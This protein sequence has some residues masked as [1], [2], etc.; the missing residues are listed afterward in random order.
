MKQITLLY[1]FSAFTLTVLSQN[2]KFIYYL[3]AGLNSTTKENAA[4]IGRAYEKDGLIVMDCYGKTSGK[5]ILSATFKDSTLGVLHG[6]YT[7]YFEN[8]SIEAQGKYNN[9]EMDGWWKH[10]VR[11]GFIE[12]SVFYSNG[13][14]TIFGAYWYSFKK[15]YNLKAPPVDS[16]KMEGYHYRYS[17]TDSLN[18]TFYEKSCWV[19]KGNERI[20]YEVNF[21]GNRGLLKEY[22]STGHV[23]TDSVFSREATEAAFPGGEGAWRDFLYR[24]LN[25]DI[26]SKN[27]APSGIYTVI[28]KF[29]VNKDGTLDEITAENDA[30]YG[31]AAEAVR[32]LKLSRKWKPAFQYGKYLKAYRRQPLSF[33]I[34]N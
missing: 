1:L 13:A 15:N 4:A 7:S 25:I 21:K 12:D 8:D 22:D 20:S 5:K 33:Q 29:V 3:D 19:E 26:L 18:D 16:I 23:N 28:V 10:W 27:N 24:N 17:F 31:T 2:Y 6:M 30:G 11:A 14:R 34:Q 9:N 32:V